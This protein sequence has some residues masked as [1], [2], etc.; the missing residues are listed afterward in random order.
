MI[1]FPRIYAF[2]ELAECLNFTEAAERLYMTQSS[3]SKII[4]K[5]EET[6]NCKLFIRSNRSVE[7]TPAGKYL[8]EYFTASTKD[9]HQAIER[10]RRLNDGTEGRL[11]ML[12]YGS[13]FARNRFVELMKGF[14]GV[15]PGMDISFF[16]TNQKEARKRLLAN[17]CDFL[18]TRKAEVEGFSS[19]DYITIDRCA[20]MIIMS[21]R[22]PA[23][24]EHPEPELRDLK[25][26]A[27]VTMT[28]DYSPSLHNNLFW[29]CQKHGFVPQDVKTVEGRPEMMMEV[30]VN[31]RIAILDDYEALES[32]DFRCVTIDD[33]EPIDIVL[34]WNMINTNPAVG[35]L[36]DYI[37][38]LRLF[39]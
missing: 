25:D 32:Y 17:R 21:S 4:A 23:L 24:R 29:Y 6:V 5:F 7:L 34:A 37:R 10:A 18:L 30:T 28:P 31:D 9:M 39:P 12:G 20:P 38:G 16:S 19:C 33:D 1:E 35:M 2:C 11:E 22:H 3:L 36:T 15:C 8:Y 13:V 14:K 26:Y 27:F